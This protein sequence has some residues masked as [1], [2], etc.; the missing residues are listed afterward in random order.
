MCKKR[1]LT[2][3]RSWE[4]KRLN[5]RPIYLRSVFFLLAAAQS[6]CHVYYDYDNVPLP[7][8]T[9]LEDRLPQHSP[10]LQ[11]WLS[12]R[13]D[14]MKPMFAWDPANPAK[15]VPKNIVLRTL[16]ICVS[17]P[18][19]YGFFI[20]RTAWDWSYTFAS[21]LSDVPAS[22]LSFMPPHYPSLVYRS[23]TAGVLL[24]FLWQSSNALFAAYVARP[25]IKKGQ[26][27]STD[28]KD[29]NGTLLNGLRSKKHIANVC[30]H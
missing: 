2:W 5:E 19:L 24:T 9:P 17:A 3:R 18:F 21:L 16:A 28:S 15:S 4:R 12:A 29:T 23:I 7:I 26:P 11:T 25:P 27:L 14:I 10:D 20:R 30:A 1:R 13:R 8:A 22:Q 6:I